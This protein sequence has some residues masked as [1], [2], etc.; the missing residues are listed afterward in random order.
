MDPFEILG[1]AL[2][3]KHSKIRHAPYT[4][5]GRIAGTHRAFIG[6]ANRLLIFVIDHVQ[7]SKVARTIQPSHRNIILILISASEDLLQ[8]FKDFPVVVQSRGYLPPNLE[9]VARLYLDQFLVC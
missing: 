6:I 3:L 5:N 9:S 1:R 2:A 8:Y 7:Q 4:D